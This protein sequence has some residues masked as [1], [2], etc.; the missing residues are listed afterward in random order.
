MGLCVVAG[1]A[2]VEE[3]VLHIVVPKQE[4]HQQDLVTDVPVE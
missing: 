3:G 2:K 4:E 1:Q